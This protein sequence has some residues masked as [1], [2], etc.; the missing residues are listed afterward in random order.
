MAAPR[1]A[2][3]ASANGIARNAGLACGIVAPLIYAATDV[4]AGL[5]WEGYSFLNQTISELNA[6]GAPT[7]PLT[8]ILGLVGY[9]LLLAFAIEVWRS[10]GQNRR[11]RAVGGVLVVFS[12]LALWAVPFASMHVRGAPRSLGD[13]LHLV[14]GAI[15]V[16]LLVAVIGFGAAVF[17]RPYR[18]YSIVMILVLLTFG[19]WAAMDGARVANDLPTPWVGLKERISVYSYQLWLAAFAVGLLRERVAGKAIAGH[20]ETVL[21]ESDTPST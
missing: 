14:G 12:I 16:L 1:T 13:T 9:T 5:R 7:R 4:L 15:A 18:V 10:A 6:I 2:I 3:Q 21:R 20:G 11:L 17:G 19:A 8:I